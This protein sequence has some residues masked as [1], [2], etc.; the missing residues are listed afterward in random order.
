MCQKEEENFVTL[1]QFIQQERK[2]YDSEEAQKRR[3]FAQR[4]IRQQIERYGFYSVP[5]E[6]YTH[7]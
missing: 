2:K 7:G 6:A 5:I 4:Y 3:S 1:E